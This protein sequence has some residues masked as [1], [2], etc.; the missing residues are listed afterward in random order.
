MTRTLLIL[1]SALV[2]LVLLAAPATAQ[3]CTCTTYQSAR[4]FVQFNDAIFRGKVVAS[5]NEHGIATTRFQVL[6]TLK[7]EPGAQATVTHPAPGPGRCGGVAFEPGQTVLI[8]A[9][10]LMED[11]GTTSCQIS[12]YSEEE[13]RAALQ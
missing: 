2:A 3:N 5:T 1:A 7:G 12:A 4:Q 10:G 11:L 6:E 13:L 9:Q 8:V